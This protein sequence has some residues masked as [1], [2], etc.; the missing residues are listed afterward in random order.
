MEIA[1]FL[2]VLSKHNHP[3]TVE[4]TM[5]AVR[6]LRGVA[7]ITSLYDDVGAEITAIRQIREDVR[8]EILDRARAAGSV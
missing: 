2:V 1:A 3:D 4:A 7:G 5:A 6:Q 8:R